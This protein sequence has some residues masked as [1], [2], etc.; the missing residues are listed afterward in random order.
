M[1]TLTSTPQQDGYRM[2]GEFEEHQGV[3]ILWSQRP[4]NWRNGGK[5][6]QHTFVK[7]AEAISQFE[8]VTVG[9]NDDQYENARTM[10]PDNVEVVEIS[11][12]DSWVRDCGAT[13]VKNDKGGLR[14]V[15]W[16][17]NSWGGL[18]DGL[19]FPWDKDDRVAQKMAEMEH[20][21]RYR[22]DDFILEGGSIH[23]D[24]EG[25]LITTE[26][27][28]LSKGR[29]AQL[30]KEQ[31]EEVL[32]THLNL[33]KIIWLKNGIYNDETN[34]HVDNI[35][36]FVKPGVVALAWTD[37]QNDPQYQIS[38]ENLDILEHATDAKGRQIKVVKLNVPKPVLITKEE[39][40]GVD[41][42]DGTLPRQAGDRLAASYVNYYTANGGIVYPTFGDPADDNAQKVL[43]QLYPDRKVVGVP[44]REILLGGGNIHCITQQVPKA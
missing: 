36:N 41:A 18:V 38:K 27:C 3:Y 17:F 20:V 25:T 22:L 42:V 44:A 9:V 37:D 19:Y 11:N 15:D 28:L 8:H 33:K 7:V 5:P 16:T 14:A 21:D 1:K 13:F 23:V 30:S 12:N 39:S 32:K 10:L 6:A 43:E 29:N 24:G 35:A 2:P 40:E 34:G 26:E 31:I 4:D